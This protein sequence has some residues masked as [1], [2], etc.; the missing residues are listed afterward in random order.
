MTTPAT[1]VIA[2][3]HLIDW[4]TIVAII[5]GPLVG[6]WVTRFIDKAKEKQHQKW[7]I[8]VTL[9]KMRGQF[10]S[11]ENVG[12][13][14]MIPIIFR[15][16]TDVILKWKSLISVFN[17]TGWNDQ[18][19]IPSLNNSVH[20]RVLDLIEVIGKALGANLPNENEFKIGYSP[21]LWKT[22]EDE[23]SQI[24][25]GLISLL[26]RKSAINTVTFI[27]ELQI[28]QN[29]SSTDDPSSKL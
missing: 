16:E 6:I 10:L 8:F 7:Q 23:Q 3:I 12:A 17:D 11:Y 4:L 24:R 26:N 29:Q 9:I 14:N 5:I 15:D 18:A 20:N 28:P 1:D 21:M 22:I 19:K 25:Q 13:L 27:T 2:N